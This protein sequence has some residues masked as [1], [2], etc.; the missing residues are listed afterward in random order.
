[1]SV[2]ILIVTRS[3]LRRELLSGYLA[4]ESGFQVAAATSELQWVKSKI[5]RYKADVVLLDGVLIDELVDF[6]GGVEPCFESLPTVVMADSASPIRDYMLGKLN[7]GPLYRVSEG[8][9]QDGTLAGEYGEELMKVLQCATGG[10][11]CDVFTRLED[12]LSVDF[13]VPKSEQIPLGGGRPRLIVMGASMG[14]V[15]ALKKLFSRLPA[16]L[17]PIAITEHIPP[18][19]SK[20]FARRLDDLSTLSVCEAREGMVLRAGHAYVAPGDHHLMITRE[21]DDFYCALNEGP[22]VNR[23]KPSVDVLF[24]SALQAAGDE[25]IGVLLTGM[26]DDGARCLLEMREAGVSTIAQDRETSVV[27][28]MPGEAVKLGAAEQ[29]LPLDKIPPAL[30][31]LCGEPARASTYQ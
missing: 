5:N 7:A 25:L 13:V 1:M 6:N 18:R 24:R 19:F 9:H 30:E 21:G 15:D 22:H 11:R 12:K 20:V 27:W 8:R 16:N 3:A 29:V 23:H 31:S 10:G 26:G 2:K 14:G 4:G 28:G 17:P